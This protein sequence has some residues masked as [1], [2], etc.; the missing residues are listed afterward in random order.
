MTQ[1]FAPIPQ[2]NSAGS[3]KSKPASAGPTKVDSE[4]EAQPAAFSKLMAGAMAADETRA[5]QRSADEA[6]NADPAPPGTAESRGDG[7][8]SLPEAQDSVPPVP[9][10]PDS[11]EA[12]DPTSLVA[13]GPV[14]GA[15]QDPVLLEF[16]APT[17]LET[18][19]SAA[20][21][22]EGGVAAKASARLESD[23]PAPP[24]AASP[25][26]REA[27]DASTRSFTPGPNGSEVKGRADFSAQREA[28]NP[29]DPNE[30]SATAELRTK[31]RA[32]APVLGT[33]PASSQPSTGE[34]APSAPRGPM[35]ASAAQPRPSKA[36]QSVSHVASANVEHVEQLTT[37][38]KISQTRLDNKASSTDS[39]V[40]PRPK[41]W[42]FR[43]AGADQ[44]EPATSKSSHQTQALNSKQERQSSKPIVSSPGFPLD[45]HSPD[46]KNR[47]PAVGSSPQTEPAAGH[48]FASS[49]QSP[50]D[51]VGPKVGVNHPRVPSSS[52]QLIDAATD[53]TSTEPAV[54]GLA[55]D[56]PSSKIHNEVRSA[57]LNPGTEPHK[58]K[59]GHQNRDITGLRT[60]VPESAQA[61]PQSEGTG[62]TE[63][64]GGPSATRATPVVV[65]ASVAASETRAEP[66][67]D[68]PTLR[69]R[70]SSKVAATTPADRGGEA[71]ENPEDH[72]EDT[73]RDG[74]PQRD[75]Q[76][77][78]TKLAHS[79]SHGQSEQR[80]STKAHSPVQQA[81]RDIRD[82]YGHWPELRHGSGESAFSGEPD[83]WQPTLDGKFSTATRTGESASGSASTS[84]VRSEIV[85]QL[86]A[87]R[88]YSRAGTRLSI[89]LPGLGRVDIHLRLGHDGL[90]L[91]LGTVDDRAM[92][93][94]QREQG[95][96]A[97][98]LHVDGRPAIIEV[99]PGEE[100]QA[101]DHEAAHDHDPQNASQGTHEDRP[102][103]KGSGQMS[104]DT[105][106]NQ[107]PPVQ[108]A[109]A[110]PIRG[111]RLIDA[112][113]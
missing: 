88:P 72:S 90:N 68:R 70:A 105:R 93:V 10:A 112:L 46:Q 37:E 33:D 65:Q 67:E 38:S 17:R 55:E 12:G 77:S 61:Q 92:E 73:R 35:P 62:A 6:S 3:T 87:M 52:A 23:A 47:A 76:R 54:A 107:L 82:D 41:E 20:L 108:N 96:L 95:A 16:D 18:R 81:L 66:L 100:L 45:A 1:L 85:R 49:R 79:P 19:D 109:G 89:T 30:T 84:G 29:R 4:G 27:Q 24:K 13:H 28:S 106:S 64:S 74:E 99:R 60:R 78:E 91:R 9:D 32:I 103:G 34:Q 104:S 71:S 101:R 44:L 48:D 14:A 98:A 111:D 97:R 57:G 83:A 40:D 39:S 86:E 31:A 42:A 102:Q 50:V 80:A 56:T 94:L 8:A 69:Q 63:T 51:G 26:V 75:A 7:E 21:V 113:A 11:P 59:L 53:S 15:A 2:P 43:G 110:T 5:A 36:Q 58:P 25:R 22:A